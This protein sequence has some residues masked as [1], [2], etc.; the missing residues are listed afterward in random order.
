MIGLPKADRN[1]PYVGTATILFN[2]LRLA[3]MDSLPIAVSPLRVLRCPGT[4]CGYVLAVS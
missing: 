1:I 2:K 4:P 3:N